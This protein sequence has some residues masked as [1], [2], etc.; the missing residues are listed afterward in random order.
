MRGGDEGG[1]GRK[2]EGGWEG[3]G[4]EGRRGEKEMEWGEA[5]SGGDL[6][7][8]S[9]QGRFGAGCVESTWVSLGS[10]G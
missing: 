4:G 5:G 6:V 3:R 8:M 7:G 10:M 9:G 2:R 1:R